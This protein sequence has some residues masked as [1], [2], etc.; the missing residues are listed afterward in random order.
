[1]KP[2]WSYSTSGRRLRHCILLLMVSKD[3]LEEPNI[4]TW[5]EDNASRINLKYRHQHIL[6]DNRKYLVAK[7]STLPPVPK[8]CKL[9]STVAARVTLTWAAHGRRGTWPP[10]GL[11]NVLI[12]REFPGIKQPISNQ[13]ITVIVAMIKWSAPGCSFFKVGIHKCNLLQKQSVYNLLTNVRWV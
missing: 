3:T 1:M 2:V 5:S 8:A 6:V 12:G 13:E 9:C 11:A 7:L 10:Q 4:R